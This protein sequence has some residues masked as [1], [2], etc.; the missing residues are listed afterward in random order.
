M[1][2]NFTEQQRRM[3]STRLMVQAP[4]GIPVAELAHQRR[5]IE[6]LPTDVLMTL[7]ALLVLAEQGNEIAQNLLTTERKRLGIDRRHYSIR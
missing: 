7:E 1:P 6:G 2:L 3:L 5:S 4:K